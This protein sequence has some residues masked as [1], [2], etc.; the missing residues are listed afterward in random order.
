MNRYHYLLKWIEKTH[1]CNTLP[2]GRYQKYE[3]ILWP[4][5]LQI[6]QDESGVQYTA[7]ELPKGKRVWS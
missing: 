6:F 3:S 5:L 1:Y 4:K 7:Y 2:I